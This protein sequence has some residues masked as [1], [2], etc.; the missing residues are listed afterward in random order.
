MKLNILR[1][2]ISIF[3][4]FGVS[5]CS[6]SISEAEEIGGNNNDDS[7][8]P[9]SIAVIEF[10]GEDV[11]SLDE[12]EELIDLINAE[13]SFTSKSLLYNDSAKL[14]TRR[15]VIDHLEYVKLA[16]RYHFGMNFSYMD[17]EDFYVPS[18][19][20]SESFFSEE[21]KR[22]TNESQEIIDIEILGPFEIGSFDYLSMELK[23]DEERVFREHFNERIKELDL[24]LEEYD[25]VVV[26]FFSGAKKKS[27]HSFARQEEG[28][29][30]VDFPLSKVTYSKSMGT[31][32]HEIGHLLGA[33][34]S[35][36]IKDKEESY[37]NERGIYDT[38]KKPLFPQDR[39]CLMCEYIMLGEKE[40]MD[41]PFLANY[42]VCEFEAKD[43][44]WV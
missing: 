14:D 43:M 5:S 41:A 19:R 37:C 35:Y 8:Y 32:M 22:Y 36:V 34:D 31:F 15:G 24:S 20:Y 17:Y 44:G 25:F 30:Y 28:I 2:L 10:F 18:L 1:F 16:H 13:S 11:K 4:I 3:F 39:A 26:V 40:A 12:R 7:K 23:E 42:A 6:S 33:K 21:F 9:Y 29:A 27:F 38:S